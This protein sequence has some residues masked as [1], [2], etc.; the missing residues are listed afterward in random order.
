[1][2]RSSPP[3]ILLVFIAAGISN[4]VTQANFHTEGG[5]FKLPS[6]EAK[7]NRNV[8]ATPN[9][10]YYDVENSNDL[11]NSN[12]GSNGLSMAE[13]EEAL[14]QEQQRK[15]EDALAGIVEQLNKQMQRD[16]VAYD[17]T[18]EMKQREPKPVHSQFRQ[19]QREQDAE[20]GAEIEGLRQLGNK[21]KEL[22]QTKEE[23]APEEEVEVEEAPVEK[24]K[25][26]HEKPLTAQ[27]K[28]QSEYVEF[29]EPVHLNKK[30]LH[31]E[32]LEKRLASDDERISTHG[33]HYRAFKNLVSGSGNIIFVAFVTMCCVFSVVGVVGGMYYY[34]HVR[35]SRE[36][37]FDDFT[38]YSPAGPGRDK[39]KKGRGGNAN[40]FG[41][42]KGDESLA[43]KAQL[44][45]YQQTKQKIIGEQAGAGS[46]DVDASDKSDDEGDLEHNF[47]VYECPGLAPTGDIE[48]QNPNFVESPNSGKKPLPIG[49]FN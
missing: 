33:H 35:A 13:Y 36:D 14:Q 12:S 31:K 6:A 46:C 25:K 17:E 5:D 23:F 22:S 24:P 2:W 43:Y 39:L 27:K 48:V 21:F 49:S 42:E 32:Y 18:V 11:V 7:V 40:T 16:S 1:M 37:P 20:V 8:Q 34:N 15:S 38:R 4:H 19:R 44:H 10:E 28:G 26:H 3:F 29:I 30:L 9:N 41:G 47:S 45:H